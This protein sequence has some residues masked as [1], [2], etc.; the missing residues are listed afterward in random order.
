MNCQK[1]KRREATRHES[2][3]QEDGT[4]AE[5]HL[6][7]RCAEKGEVTLLSPASMIQAFLENAAAEARK[8]SGGA[9]ACPAC[10]ITY[11][12]F[13]ARGRLGCPADYDVFVG[14]LLPLIERIH[15]GGTQHV[16]KSPSSTDG[17][18]EVERELIE[19][20]RTLAEAVQREQYEEAARLRD[21]IRI[22]EEGAGS[23]RGR[24]AEKGEGAP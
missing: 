10:G 16:G 2:V 9:A 4:W 17:R 21:R 14:D 1:C 18:S 20:R 6:C 12:E 23:A 3:R 24:G 5:V 11:A 8:A 15:Q 19:L 22:L 7:D 13:R